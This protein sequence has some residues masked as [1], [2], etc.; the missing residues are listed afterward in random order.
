[1]GFLTEMGKNFGSNAVENTPDD[2]RTETYSQASETFPQQRSLDN[3][4][5][6]PFNGDNMAYRTSWIRISKIVYEKDSAF[7]DKLSMIYTALHETA[8]TVVMVI[9]KEKNSLI[10]LYMGVCDK[11]DMGNHVSKYVLQRSIG[12]CLPGISFEETPSPFLTTKKKCYVAS[13]SGQPMQKTD[14]GQVFSQGIEKLLNATS[15][16]PTYTIIFIAANESRESVNAEYSYLVDSYSSLATN[17]EI[18]INDSDNRSETT[19]TTTTSGTSNSAGENKSETT[20][21]NETKSETHSSSESRSGGFGFFAS[22]NQSNS[23]SETLGISKTEGVASMT[24]YSTTKGTTHSEAESKGE[25]NTHGHSE[26]KK[27]EDKDAKERLKILDKKIELM[28]MEDSLGIW[29]FAS[30]FITDTKTS[31]IV[32]ASIYK[33]LIVGNQPAASLYSVNIYD[34]DK[35]QNILKYLYSCRHPQFV[36]GNKDFIASGVFVST[37]ELCIGMSLPQTSVPGI[38]VKEQATFGR[39]VLICGEKPSNVVKMGSLVHLGCEEQ[40][41]TV[42]LDEDLLTSH[43]FVTGT[44]GCG[45][46]NSIYTLLSRLRERGKK[47]LIIE[48]AKGEY[49]NVFGG[50]KNVRVLGTNPKLMEQLRINPFCFPESIHVEEHIDRLIDIFNACWPMYAAMPAVLK[51]A[52]SRAY[53]ACGWDLIRSTSDYEVFP[54]FDDVRRELNIYVNESEYSSDSK[55]DYKGALGTR[56]QSLTNGIIGQ[57]FAGQ[58]ISNEELF[59]ENVIIDLSR[60]GSVETKSLIMG[61][62]IIK[63][64]EFRMSENMGMNQPLRHVT[65][66]EE[67]HNLLRA[68]SGIQTQENANLAGKSVEMLASAI[69]EMRTYGEGFII[70]D[71]SPTLLD[72]AAI[73]NTN[74]KLI[75]NLPNFSDREIAANSIGLSEQQM[76]ELSKLKTGIAIVYQKGWEEPVQCLID[77][78]DAPQPYTGNTEDF[79]NKAESEFIKKLYTSYTDLPCLESVIDDVKSIGL[80]GSRLIRIMDI[81]NDAETD[82]QERCTRIFVAYVGESLF[83]RAAKVNNVTD[84]NRLVKQGLKK[85][86]GICDD[87]IET[88]LNMYVKGCA[89]MNKTD[90]YETWLIQNVKLKTG[91]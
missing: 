18:T 62:L 32:L 6:M 47:F 39:N 54:T 79:E 17:S 37:K 66:L 59:N 12:G 65:V 55:G 3:L 43:V 70:A 27:I 75:M 90:F 5:V 89:L 50:L 57:I 11:A 45:K 63:L 33:G 53:E 29:S 51:E 61:M 26:Q 68:T 1:M 4:E 86:K 64:N 30:Y 46:S 69:A 76:N 9:Q 85:I 91:K 73:S 49:K 82:I 41:N 24:G 40:N 20:N 74:T 10:N 22:G 34:N 71:Q 88:F 44:T 16:I 7:I 15:D 2:L 36:V 42:T 67:A 19:Q 13:V 58:S 38:L 52:I 80:N 28:K 77:R 48:P 14:K 72:R 83:I 87:N 81:M 78:Y 23:E 31:S 8:K 25:N 35:S 60:V 21:K 56:L 84:F